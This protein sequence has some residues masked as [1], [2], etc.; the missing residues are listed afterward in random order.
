MTEEK[1][2]EAFEAWVKSPEILYRGPDGEYESE[3]V[4]AMWDAWQAAPST[5]QSPAEAE[6]VEV[7]R[8]TETVLGLC[9]HLVQDHGAPSLLDR[10]ERA[11]R[12]RLATQARPDAE[13]AARSQAL[14][15]AAINCPHEIDSN[16][17]VLHFDAKQPGH[18]ALNQLSRRLDAA[19]TSDAGE[20]T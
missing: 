1:M 14:Y 3:I 7:M 11:Q 2:R 16:R 20:R 19:M 4:D 9:W 10:L 13:D 8:E 15:M 6:P 5:P 12:A 18:N 17:V